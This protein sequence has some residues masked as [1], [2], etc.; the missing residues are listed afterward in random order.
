MQLLLLTHCLIKKI[1]RKIVPINCKLKQ[2]RKFE[3][4]IRAII[5]T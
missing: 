4:I 5:I 1:V 2:Y 3:H